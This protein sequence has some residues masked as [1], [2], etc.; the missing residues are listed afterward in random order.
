M[1]QL[2]NTINSGGCTVDEITPFC[3]ESIYRSAIFFGQEYSRTGRLSE[4]AS[5]AA[6]KEALNEIGKRWK[7]ACKFL[8]F[9]AQSKLKANLL[10]FICA[11]DWC[12]TCYRHFIIS[13]LY[14]G[15][16]DTKSLCECFASDINLF[17]VHK[18]WTDLTEWITIIVKERDFL[19]VICSDR[20]K[21]EI[22]NKLKAV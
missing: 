5:C 16:D 15:D 7:A 8:F 10:S 20:N 19:L 11:N 21:K 4:A 22:S 3:L 18:H 9:V 14:L 2:A 13:N 17:P 6:I 12:T 1:L